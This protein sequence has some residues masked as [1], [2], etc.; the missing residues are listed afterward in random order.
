VDA[1]ATLDDLRAR[2]QARFNPRFIAALLG[3]NGMEMIATP[4]VTLGRATP[5]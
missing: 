1:A 2:V 4:S 5:N 3:R